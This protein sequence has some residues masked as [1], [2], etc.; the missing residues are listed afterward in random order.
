MAAMAPVL[1]QWDHDLSSPLIENALFILGESGKLPK[2]PESLQNDRLVPE[3]I[4]VL[5][6]ASKASL[7]AS[8][9]KYVQFVAGTAEMLQDPTLLKMA[10]GESLIRAYAENE[11]ISPKLVL[12]E[13]QFKDAREAALEAQAQQAQQEAAAQQAAT[14]KTMADT[15]IGNGS[16]LDQLIG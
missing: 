8:Q 7:T 3:Y 15:P 10:D 14:A 11:G 16:A 6:Q 9:E 2:K 4:S 12:D 1:G 5:A 13:V